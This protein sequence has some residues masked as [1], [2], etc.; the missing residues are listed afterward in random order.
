[1]I[2]RLLAAAVA[3]AVPAMPAFA[4][5]I[6][7]IPEQLGQIFCVARLANDM[8]AAGGLL[9]PGLVQAIA[10]AE[11]ANAEIAAQ[12][13]DEKPPLGDGIPWAAWP[14]HP[15]GCTPGEPQWEM[16]EA[17]LKVSYAFAEAPDAG[18]TDT[19]L[20]KLEPGP[21]GTTAWRID[22]LV[23]ATGGD[24]RTTLLSAFMD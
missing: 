6:Y 14:D 17:R 9:T 21:Y 16:D 15:S 24:L 7:L 5:D 12:N 22:N 19:L 3:A 13:P 11:A 18:F 20:L 4:Q 23:Y 1:M 8:P 10:E 2:R